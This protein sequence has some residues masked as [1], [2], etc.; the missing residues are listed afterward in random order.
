MIGKEPNKKN[1]FVNDKEQLLYAIDMFFN[2]KL[3]KLVVKG[4]E[5]KFTIERSE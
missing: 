1:D 2:H 4:E 3:K 5:I